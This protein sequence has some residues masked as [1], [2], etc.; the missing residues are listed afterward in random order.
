MRAIL[1]I[2]FLEND[3]KKDF[4]AIPSEMTQKIQRKEDV[5]NHKN[6]VKRCFF[7]EKNVF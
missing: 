7:Q 5:N 4:C 1:N 2:F 6:I 3:R